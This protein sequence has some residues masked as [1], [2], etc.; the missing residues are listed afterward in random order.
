MAEFNIDDFPDLEWGMICEDEF[1][2]KEFLKYLNDQ[3]RRWVS[4]TSYLEETHYEGGKI[5]YRFNNGSYNN[6]WRSIEEKYISRGKA[7]Y[8]KDFLWG[9]EDECDCSFSVSI[10]D[11]F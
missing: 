9:D 3:G 8:F 7:L 1:E 6:W 2:V 10:T 5:L 4:G 11:I